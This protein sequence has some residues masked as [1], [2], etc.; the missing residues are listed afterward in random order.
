MKL[1]AWSGGVD[2]TAALVKTL[3][4]TE[5]P[6]RTFEVDS[7]HLPANDFQRV[8]RDALEVE[9]ERDYRSFDRRRASFSLLDPVP[10]SGGHGLHQMGLW[11]Q[12]LPMY[13]APAEDVVLGWISGDDA[14]HKA[15][16]ARQAW[17]ALGE[18]HGLDGA[19]VTPLEWKTKW[20]AVRYLE[21]R[22]LYRFT[23]SC[24]NPDG[25]RR[26]G[27]CHKCREIQEAEFRLDAGL[28]EWD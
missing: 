14:W 7:P 9:I 6:V 11:L 25:A 16:A 18:I 22:G 15:H 2:S 4:G 28:T 19:L 3:E 23:W 13:T 24:P 8:S 10:D 5:E 1:V 26:C 17:A 20:W 12:L 27:E 21:Q